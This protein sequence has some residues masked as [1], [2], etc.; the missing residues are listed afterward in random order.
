MSFTVNQNHPESLSKCT[1]PA[2]QSQ[3]TRLGYTWNQH[4]E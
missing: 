1:F 2:F 3:F 4:F